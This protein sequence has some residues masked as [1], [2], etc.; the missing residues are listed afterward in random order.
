MAI[1]APFSGRAAVD[2]ASM[3]RSLRGD[4]WTEYILK[5]MYDGRFSRWSVAA[6]SS[7]TSRRM[8]D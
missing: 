2:L 4:E 8:E 1:S 5:T 7:I 6:R 3:G